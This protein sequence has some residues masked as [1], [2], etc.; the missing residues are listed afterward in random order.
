MYTNMDRYGGFALQTTSISS[1][2]DG[3]CLRP[4]GNTI[5][6]LA[7]YVITRCAA[8]KKYIKTI[9]ESLVD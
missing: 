1:W 9:E 4:L 3:V 2:N 5:Y 6:I 8:C 7:P